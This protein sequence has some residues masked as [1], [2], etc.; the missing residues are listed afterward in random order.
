MEKKERQTVDLNQVIIKATPQEYKG[1]KTED[2]TGR[3]LEV[4]KRACNGG[5]VVECLPF[6]KGLVGEGTVVVAVKC[7]G[8]PEQEQEKESEKDEMDVRDLLMASFC[9]PRKIRK[10]TIRK[11]TTADHSFRVHPSTAEEHGLVEG[12]IPLLETPHGKYGVSVKIDENSEPGSLHCQAG[13]F[14]T[15]FSD[16]FPCIKES[17]EVRCREVTNVAKLVSADFVELSTVSKP[18]LLNLPQDII[19]TALMELFKTNNPCILHVGEVLSLPLPRD[20]SLTASLIALHAET[21]TDPTESPPTSVQMVVSKAGSRNLSLE[22]APFKVTLGLTEIAAAGMPVKSLAVAETPM[23]MLPVRD[24]A[25]YGALKQFVTSVFGVA[26]PYP[27]TCLVVGNELNGVSALVEECARAT[28]CHYVKVSG[29]V[30][31][32]ADV[33]KMIGIAAEAEPSFLHISGC[34]GLFPKEG[35]DEVTSVLKKSVHGKRVIVVCSTGST[36]S[37]PSTFTSFFQKTITLDNPTG[38]ERTAVYTTLL[39]KLVVSLAATPERLGKATAGLTLTGLV[40]TLAGAVALAGKRAVPWLSEDVRVVVQMCDF[41]DA[42]ADFTKSHQIDITTTVQKVGWKDIGGLKEV[43]QEIMECIHL[44]MTQPQLFSASGLKART[45]IL[46]FGPPGCGKTLLAKGVATECG[47]NFM[48]VK[49]PEM[50]NMYVGESERNIRELFH[51]ARQAAPCIV[52]FD[53]LDALVPN[54]GAKGDSGGVMDRIVAQLLTEVDSLGGN[55][56]EFVFII[57]ATNRPDL[58][59]QSLLRPGRF[60]RCVYLG[61][62]GTSEEQ[63]TILKAQTRKMKLDDDVDFLGLTKTMPKTYSGADLYALSTEALMLAMRSAVDNLITTVEEQRKQAEEQEEEDE[64]H[65]PAQPPTASLNTVVVSQK[66][67][68]DAKNST[69]PSITVGDLA[70]YQAMREQFT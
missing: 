51:K 20:P 14:L 41:T 17:E 33:G 28:G 64:G 61:V 21:C 38:D 46:M 27:G 3:Y 25:A 36:D 49:G 34:E 66:H 37:V 47:L 60:D 1:I 50:L 53:E 57:G 9:R 12:S 10:F 23:G 24:M 67:F 56:D 15:M 2:F 26:E 6:T 32:A 30:V 43:K 31:D 35:V 62:S 42:I 44:P 45:G 63:A 13:L 40:Q 54:R 18:S 16:R 7:E 4:G 39:E 68:I 52:F 29:Q 58:I 69:T 65:Q 11:G 70:R 19:D 22:G 59:D 48:S 5:V 55:P 8:E